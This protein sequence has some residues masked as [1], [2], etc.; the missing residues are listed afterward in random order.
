MRLLVLFSIFV[1][2]CANPDILYIIID[3]FGFDNWEQTPVLKNL[4]D[5]SVVFTRTYHPESMCTPNRGTLMTGRYPRRYGLTYNSLAFRVFTSPYHPNG[6][7]LSEKT[8]GT[9]LSENGYDT[10]YIGKWHLGIG[11]KCKYCPTNHGFKHYYGMPL[12][13][14]LTC[15]DDNI[16]TMKYFMIIFN[17]YCDKNSYVTPGRIVLTLLLIAIIC[18]Y[19]YNIQFNV[20]ILIYFVLML[21]LYFSMETLIIKVICVGV[22]LFGTMIYKK[23]KLNL[24]LH[25]VIIVVML[26]YFY[27]WYCTTYFLLNKNNC[28]LMNDTTIVERPVNI[29]M[30]TTMLTDEAIRVIGEKDVNQP[31]LMIVSFDKMHTAIGTHPNFVNFTGTGL[32][33]DGVFELDTSIGTI[34]EVMKQRHNDLDIWIMSDNGPHREEGEYSGNS[35]SLRGGKGQAYEGGVRTKTIFNTNRLIPKKHINTPIFTADI[36]PTIMCIIG[37]CSYNKFDGMSLLPLILNSNDE[38]YM[39]RPIFHYCGERLHAMTFGNYKIHFETLQFEDSINEMCPQSKICP[40]AGYKNNPPIIFN[41]T[42]DIKESHPLTRDVE[43]LDVDTLY[44]M[45]SYHEKQIDYVPSVMGKYPNPF[46]QI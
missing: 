32:F 40:C 15:G 16:D 35:S 28:I 34:I 27:Y 12:T 4:I 42:D 25:P 7:S 21:F 23:N 14:A 2:V 24:K 46:I 36:L 33:N 26:A 44:S 10:E 30:V 3:D 31:L 43:N 37:N 29:N 38:P 11:H 20:L 45:V 19:K 8:I 9:L 5:T 18:R 39:E 6:L 22:L 13:N 17:R 41:V 1:V